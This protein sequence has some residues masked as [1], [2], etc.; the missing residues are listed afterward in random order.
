MIKRESD[1][2]TERREIRENKQD[3][4]CPNVHKNVSQ[5]CNDVKTERL[6]FYKFS[7]KLVHYECARMI[8]A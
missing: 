7:S 3:K 1:R 2:E 5:G 6:S 8:L 4:S